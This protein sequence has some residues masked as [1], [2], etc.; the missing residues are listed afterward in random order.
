[1]PIFIPPPPP[2]PAATGPDVSAGEEAFERIM[3][4]GCTLTR[5][6]DG[7]AGAFLDSTTGQLV[8]AALAL[9]YSGKCLITGQGGGSSTDRAGQHVV[10]SSPTLYLPLSHMRL[11]PAA[12]PHRGDY[13]TVT[14]S[15]RDPAMVGRVYEVVD[16]SGGTITVSRKCSLVFRG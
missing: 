7:T 6:L 3:D 1:M 15:R 9:V 12:E 2:V 16:L 8:Q 14:S 10:P 5:D 4:D 13:V 11:N